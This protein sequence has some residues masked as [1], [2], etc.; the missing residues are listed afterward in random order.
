MFPE[1]IAL[2]QEA[3]KLGEDSTGRQINLGVV[4]ARSGATDKARSILT[5][6]QTGASYVSPAELAKLHESLGEREQAFA[7][8][9]KAF[10]VHDVQLQYLGVDPA[11]DNFRGDARFA[12][13]L[14]KIGLSQTVP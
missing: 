12:Q 2:Y 9:E 3:I 8:L 7:L 14:S 13:L 5:Q 10:A 11:Y 4:Y 6:L 1:A